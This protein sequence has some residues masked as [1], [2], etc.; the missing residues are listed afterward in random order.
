ML[1]ETF[2]IVRCASVRRRPPAAAG[3][4]EF[5]FSP[6]DGLERPD[7]R[8]CVPERQQVGGGNVPVVLV[9]LLRREG[10]SV[11]PAKPRELP[12]LL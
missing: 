9:C 5:V 11:F 4:G 10:V 8:L 3:H 1:N 6:A 2:A 12:L 7:P